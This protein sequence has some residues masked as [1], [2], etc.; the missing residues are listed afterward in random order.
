[1]KITNF[2]K[3]SFLGLFGVLV[4]LII[5]GLIEPKFLDIEEQTAIVPNLPPA[6]EGKL[7]G[8]LSDFQTGMWFDNTGTMRRSI[9]TLVEKRPAAVLISGDFIY[10]SLPNP[11]EELSK[12]TNAIQPLIA[13]NIPTYAVLGNHDYSHK[14]PIPEL[15]DRVKAALEK[16]GV[17]VLENQAVKINSPV[18]NNN[19]PLYLVGIGSYIANNADVNKALSQLPDN[20]PR[21]VMMHNPAS[22]AT[23]P[24]QTAPFAVAGHTHGGQ[25]RLPFTPQW[26]WVSLVKGE[27]VYGDGWIKDYGKQGNQLYVNRGIGF[28]DVPLR[29]NCPPEVTLFT[30]RSK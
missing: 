13:A 8:Q 12:V 25:I 20:S 1:M 29:I 15:G 6:W 27:E 4:V 9:E 10:H 26:S 28:S 18:V 2:L 17:T 19:Q 14:P 30:L 24:P 16:I 21:V 23:F 3:Y 7:I 5:W 22:F 11:S